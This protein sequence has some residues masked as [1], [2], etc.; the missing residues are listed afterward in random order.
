MFEYKTLIGINPKTLGEREMEIRLYEKGF[1]SSTEV[2]LASLQLSNLKNAHTYEGSVAFRGKK[3]GIR[4]EFG[5]YVREPLD[6]FTW[7]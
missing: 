2:G 4:L 1:F 7:F 5:F 6:K 3:E